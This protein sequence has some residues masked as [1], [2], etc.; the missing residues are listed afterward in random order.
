M[1]IENGCNA[2]ESDAVAKLGDTTVRAEV[3]DEQMAKDIAKAENT[4]PISTEDIAAIKEQWK[5]AHQTD[6]CKEV[7]E[8]E[9]SEEFKSDAKRLEQWRADQECHRM[10]REKFEKMTDQEFIDWAN[11]ANSAFHMFVKNT[12]TDLSKNN[13]LLLPPEERAKRYEEDALGRMVREGMTVLNTKEFQDSERRRFLK[14]TN[15]KRK[16]DTLIDREPSLYYRFLKECKF[17]RSK[18]D[19]D[20]MDKLELKTRLIQYIANVRLRDEDNE[21]LRKEQIREQGDFVRNLNDDFRR[22]LS[23]K[24]ENLVL[25]WNKFRESRHMS[26]LIDGGCDEDLPDPI[27]ESLSSP[28]TKGVSA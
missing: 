5:A 26:R 18:M 7:S 4:N 16:K 6:F 14:I 10:M 20:K 3:S 12:K 22:F 11:E 8:D 19:F 17:V 2:V 27:A 9:L 13:D 1:E 28:V 15:P 24:G 23:G 25:E 21:E